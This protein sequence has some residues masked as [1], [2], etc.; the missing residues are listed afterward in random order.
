DD[1]TTLPGVSISVKGTTSGTSTGIDG[2]YTLKASDNA[3]LIFSQ[4]GVAK[5]EISVNKR[6]E[7]NITMQDDISKLNEVVVVGYG[8][9]KKVNLSGA[10]SQIDGKELSN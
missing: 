3:V 6:R 4:I 9:Q 5:Q 7:I 1:G 2:S 8:T 10:V